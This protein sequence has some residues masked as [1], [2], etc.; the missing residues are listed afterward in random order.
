[1][2]DLPSVSGGTEWFNIHV[3]YQG[4]S[5]DTKDLTKIWTVVENYDSK[6][7]NDNNYRMVLLRWRRTQSGRTGWKAAMLSD[8]SSDDAISYYAWWPITGR[9]AE[10]WD[11]LGSNNSGQVFYDCI[12]T[13]KKRNQPTHFKSTGTSHYRVAVAIY[14]YTGEGTYGW[15]RVSNIAGIDMR[16]TSSGGTDYRTMQF[17]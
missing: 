6:L 4:S 3:K 7:L 1:M 5:S 10:W 11:N 17:D 9:M 14:K 15:H 16:G 13:A 2:V 8:P 12:S